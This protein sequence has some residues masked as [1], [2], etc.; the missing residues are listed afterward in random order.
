MITGKCHGTGR[1]SFREVSSINKSVTVSHMPEDCMT[2]RIVFRH[3]G[4]TSIPILKCSDTE[5][6]LLWSAL[7]ATAK[8]MGW[9]D[10]DF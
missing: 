10:K 5:A 2:F 1:Y 6:Q 3:N 4:E 9:E 7:N 8:D